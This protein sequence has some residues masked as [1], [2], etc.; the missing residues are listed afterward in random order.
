MVRMRM[1]L[2][3]RL[4]MIMVMVMMTMTMMTMMLT[5][6]NCLCR[7]EGQNPGP[8]FLAGAE[9]LP[10]QLTDFLWARAMGFTGPQLADSAGVEVGVEGRSV[11]EYLYLQGRCRHYKMVGETHGSAWKNHPVMERVVREMILGSGH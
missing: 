5:M 2:R 10:A 1:R 6:M 3:M 4:R 11:K 9:V 7:Y 8:D